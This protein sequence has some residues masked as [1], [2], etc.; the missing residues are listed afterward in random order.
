MPD[1][2]VLIPVGPGHESYVQ[3]AVNSVEAQ[4]EPCAFKYYYDEKGYGAGWARN[5]LLE[6]VETPFIA[7]LDA[8]DE[9]DPH[10]AEWL[11]PVARFMYSRGRYIYCSWLERFGEKVVRTTPQADC[12]C[13]LSGVE[14]WHTH[15]ITSV[16]PSM[17]AQKARFDDELSGI[18]DT[19][20]YHRLHQYGHC[21]YHVDSALMIWNLANNSRSY[22]FK[23]SPEFQAVKDK[24]IRRYREDKMCCG[25]DIPVNIGPYNDKQP[26]DVLA[27]IHEYLSKRQLIGKATGRIYP[28]VGYGELLWANPVD[29]QAEPETL[30][31]APQDVPVVQVPVIENITDPRNGEAVTSQPVWAA[32]ESVMLKQTQQAVATKAAQRAPY[33]SIVYGDDGVKPSETLAAKPDIS[34]MVKFD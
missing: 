10:F 26:G 11:L 32:V 23:R 21:G 12:Y 31:L 24:L 27:M 18:E 6:R 25:D 20:F 1:L 34:S 2:T 29:V 22:S 4:T 14:Y 13:L 7:F 3:R 9:L 33:G 5:K 17:L 30:R 19:D 16:I 8:D 28:R 15:V